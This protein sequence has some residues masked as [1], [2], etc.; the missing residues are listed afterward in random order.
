[1]I[2]YR[3]ILRLRS[4][5]VSIRNVAYSVG[6]S[7]T[8]VQSVIRKATARGLVWPLPEEIDDKEIYRI[9]FDR[10]KQATN[11]AEP[12]FEQVNKEL[13]K[14]GVTLMLLWNEYCEKSISQG[15]EPYQYSAFCQ[16]YRT[17]TKTNRI[18]AHLEHK[19]G[20]KLMVDWAG[21]TME[22]IDPDTGEVH[23]VYIFVAC[24]P[25]SSHLFAEG[26]YS[27]KQQSWQSAHINAFEYF[28]GVTPIVVPDNLKA[29]IVRNGFE[30][31]VIN[32]SYRRLAEY[33]GF[34]VVP[35]RVRKP[36]D[37][38]AVEA[39][40]GVVTRSA[41]AA[42]RHHTFFDLSELNEALREKMV[43]ISTRPFQKREGS[44]E[45]VFLDQEK[46][47][48][49]PLPPK[50]FEVYVTKTATVAYNYHISAE[51]VF[52]S[53]PFTYVKEEVEI[54]ISKNTVSVYMGTERIAIHKRSFGRRGNYVTNPDHMPD[55]HKDFVQWTGNRFRK[56][57]KSIG[58]STERVIDAILTS[59][60]IEQQA[61]RSCRAVI[62]LADT[63]GKDSLEKAC[64]R[65]LEI[66]KNPSYKT[67][68]T[69]IARINDEYVSDDNSHAY[70]RG[71]SYFD[72]NTESEK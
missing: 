43:D 67:V 46:D 69:I 48:L 40:V 10:Q 45:S 8:T 23:K 22:V 17:W 3:E 61:Y 2:K 47:T 1:M 57:A 16:K 71:A 31:L 5:G 14:K 68:K 56:W 33:Y 65:A 28:G 41:I 29:G 54:R 13:L 26:F 15:S 55:A 49:M 51:S 53:V 24:L 59:K 52:Y 44:R 21:K 72:T 38:A 42:L 27:M 4:K 6:C 12:D 37:K 32:P 62:A 25:Y 34:A 35:A 50:R 20:E 70:L 19:P 9:I 58:V 39:G 11:K 60:K 64:A 7:R 30:E 18:V 66:S 63:F 36:R